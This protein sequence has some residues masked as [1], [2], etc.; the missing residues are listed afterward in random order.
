MPI[1]DKHHVVS[2]ET[3]D[4]GEC[5]R[6]CCSYFKTKVSCTCGWEYTATGSLSREQKIDVRASHEREVVAAILGVFVGVSL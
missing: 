3:K 4:D 1:T 2:F 6:G 5:D